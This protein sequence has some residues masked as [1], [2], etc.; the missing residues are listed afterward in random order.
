[1]QRQVT[2][3]LDRSDKNNLEVS[4]ALRE[5][6]ALCAK[7]ETA[8]GCGIS[9]SQDEAAKGAGMAD[10][11][12]H[13]E[14]EIAALKKERQNDCTAVAG[15]RAQSEGDITA[16]RKELSRIGAQPA[17]LSGGRWFSLMYPYCLCVWLLILSPRAGELE[18]QFT[19]YVE[20]N[21]ATE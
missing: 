17:L 13:F 11:R 16:L 1:M 5:C 18:S 19:A 6:K 7:A 3:A 2:E 4:E 21:K 20:E 14:G 12:M 10:L 15:L 8:A 9:D